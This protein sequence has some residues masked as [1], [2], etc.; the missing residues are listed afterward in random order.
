VETRGSFEAVFGGQAVVTKGGSTY[1]YLKSARKTGELI[2]YNRNLKPVARLRLAEEVSS[3][4]LSADG[5]VIALLHLG[6]DHIDVRR[7]DTFASLLTLHAGMDQEGAYLAAVESGPDGWWIA[8]EGDPSQY[9]AYVTHYTR[10]GRPVR[11]WHSDTSPVIGSP[12]GR[13]IFMPRSSDL[14]AFDTTRGTVRRIP[15]SWRGPLPRRYL[16]KPENPKTP[17]HL[18][19]SAMTMTPDSRTLILTEWLNG[20]PAG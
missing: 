9:S 8:S 19:L 10:R 11:S 1:A 5:R 14:L 2:R 6:D 16:P 13:A 4:C 7:A 15:Y 17:I 18:Y 12:N 20:D 3:A